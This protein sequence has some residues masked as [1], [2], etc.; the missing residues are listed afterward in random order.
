MSHR[1][2]VLLDETEF[3]ELRS[4]AQREQL[5]VAEWVRQAIR[6]HRKRS[7]SSISEKMAAI[8]RACEHSFPTADIET[9]NAEIARGYE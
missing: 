4:A 2:Q 1:L 6:A 8:Q 5:T 7:E 9:M 3:K